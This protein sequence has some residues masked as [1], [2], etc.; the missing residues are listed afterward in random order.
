[1]VRI[2]SYET[3]QFGKENV[4]TMFYLDSQGV[5]INTKSLFIPNKTYGF[6]LSR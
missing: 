6:D 4:L 3:Q 1:M 2:V 5:S